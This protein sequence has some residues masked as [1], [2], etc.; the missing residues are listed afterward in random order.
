MNALYHRLETVGISRDYARRYLLPDWWDDEAGSTR[1]GLTE[2]ALLLSRHTGLPFDGVMGR[3]TLAFPS[4]T[5]KFK[6]RGQTGNQTLCLARSIAG[7]IASLCS[8]ALPPLPSK[9][10][11]ATDLRREILQTGRNWVDLPAL[12][13]K[14]W[15][16]GIAVFPL[17]GLPPGESPDAMVLLQSG[18]PYVF[19]TRKYSHSAW[20]LFVLAHEVGHYM[21]GHLKGNESLVDHSFETVI[22]S[23]DPEEESANRFAIQLITGHPDS[24]I[25]SQSGGMSAS[26]LATMA[27][28]LG[29]EHSIHP[30]HIILNFAFSAP[31]QNIWALANAALSH[32]PTETPGEELV[33]AHLERNV[34]WDNMPED[35]QEFVRR[36]TGLE[37]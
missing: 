25:Q 15:E 17:S 1:S 20:Y 13:A 30:G 16:V 22:P 29:N 32:L 33:R 26:D 6:R 5:C 23:E 31:S 19:L 34:R 3:A 37:C 35:S 27:Q 12:L 18:R 24:R 36:V 9:R 2:A 8:A 14:M 11:L 10:Y 21:L 7:Q 4:T 28:R